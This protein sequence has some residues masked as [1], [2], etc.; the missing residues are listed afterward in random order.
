MQNGLNNLLFIYNNHACDFNGLTPIYT[1][2]RGHVLE[3]DNIVL[4]FHKI[5]SRMQLS[6]VGSCSVT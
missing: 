3:I 6:H 4:S 5:E 2:N 1:L